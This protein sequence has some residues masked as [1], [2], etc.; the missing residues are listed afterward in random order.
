MSKLD[1]LRQ[2]V[3]VSPE[4][5]PLLLL[6]AHACLDEWSL[7]E[8]RVLYEKVLSLDPARPE[9]KIGVA[10]I[11]HL[12]GKTSEAIVRAEAVIQQHPEFAAAY[13]FRSRLHL[14]EG[15]RAEARVD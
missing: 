8:G 9:A 15:N 1:P 14:G 10:K 11:L 7:D 12:S 5:V 6:L 3:A 2:A 13:L 4:N